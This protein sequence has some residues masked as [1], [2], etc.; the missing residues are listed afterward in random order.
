M[1]TL[2]KGR[3]RT[4]NG[5]GEGDAHLAGHTALTAPGRLLASS[6]FRWYQLGPLGNAHV[7]LVVQHFG[8]AC[9]LLFLLLFLSEVGYKTGLNSQY[10]PRLPLGAQTVCGSAPVCA[11]LPCLELAACSRGTGLI[12]VGNHSTAR[13]TAAVGSEVTSPSFCW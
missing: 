3:G 12:L 8:Y 1:C 2:T 13:S 10:C 9:Q 11:L 7:T 6:L 5:E 4:W